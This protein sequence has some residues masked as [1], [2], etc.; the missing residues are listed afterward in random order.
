MPRENGPRSPAFGRWRADIGCPKISKINA[1]DFVNTQVVAAVW[2]NYQ[3]R[4]P[5]VMAANR[6]RLHKLTIESGTQPPFTSLG[7]L[8]SG[9]HAVSM[10]P[11]LRGEGALARHCRNLRPHQRTVTFR[12]K[13][14]A[15][16]I[17]EMFCTPDRPM[18]MSSSA[19][20][21]LKT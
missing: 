13:R 21:R 6:S 10:S 15:A 4:A 12:T 18:T 11:G 5:A 20:N 14:S 16:R 8:A 1:T 2:S 19:L 7:F 17:C 3:N 9:S